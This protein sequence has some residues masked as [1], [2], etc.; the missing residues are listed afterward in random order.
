MKFNQA[1]RRGFEHYVDF[2]GR[3]SVSEYWFWILFFWLGWVIIILF[4]KLY[5]IWDFGLFIPTV[6][7]G[8]RRMHDSNRS[9]WWLLF[10]FVNL[11]LLVS[12][13]VEPNRFPSS[14]P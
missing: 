10:P 14:A 9:G 3:A 2:S 6:A 7:V 1:V 4:T 11:F 12:P 8:V 13:A 5:Y